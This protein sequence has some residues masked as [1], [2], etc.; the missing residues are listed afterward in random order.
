[1]AAPADPKRVPLP[2][3]AEVEAAI[4]RLV[5]DAGPGKTV[6]PTDVAQELRDGPDWQRVLTPLRHAAVKL[7]L[8]GKIAIYR[9]GKPADPEDFKG[10]YRLGL[11]PRT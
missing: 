8:A 4:L 10:V 1:M 7:A 9:K 11:P 2:A 3:P 6:G 5:A